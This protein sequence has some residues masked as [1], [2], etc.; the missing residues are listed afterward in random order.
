MPLD[1]DSPP[2]LASAGV[3]KHP[4][5]T[6]DITMGNLI[7]MGIN[8]VG[9]H[10][11]D[12]CALFGNDLLHFMIDFATVIAVQ[13]TTALDQEILETGIVPTGIV[14]WHTA[15]VGGLEHPVFGRTT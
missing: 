9:E 10:W 3:I 11:Q 1:L 4:E 14:P 7:V 15:F 2:T 5:V 8:V 13:F 12:R 6:D